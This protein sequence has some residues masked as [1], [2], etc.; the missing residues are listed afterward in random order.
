MAYP[1]LRRLIHETQYNQELTAKLKHRQA[2][3]LTIFLCLILTTAQHTTL[4]SDGNMAELSGIFTEV[5][6]QKPHYT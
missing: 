5:I 4:L 2:P 6:Q 3:F 1:A